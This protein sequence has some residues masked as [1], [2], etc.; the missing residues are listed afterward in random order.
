MPQP[1]PER[2]Q[3]D[4]AGAGSG[5]GEGVGLWSA[6]P[7]KAGELVQSGGD[8][9]D[10]RGVVAFARGDQGD[11]GL[12]RCGRLRHDGVDL[13]SG[14]VVLDL[15]IG[16]GG[17]HL[18][19]DGGHDDLPYKEDGLESAKPDLQSTFKKPGGDPAGP[20]LWETLHD[21]RAETGSS[22]WRGGRRRVVTDGQRIAEGSGL[23][24]GR[25]GEDRKRRENPISAQTAIG[26]RLGEGAREAGREVIHLDHRVS[27]CRKPP[28]PV[29]ARIPGSGADR[30]M[31]GSTRV[32]GAGGSLGGRED[33][34]RPVDAA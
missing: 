11:L 26:P 2:V 9:A 24:I 7:P 29:S 16:D 20:R 32:R 18:F 17:L 21:G 5:A 23:R 14:H 4:G 6:L 27:S 13:V 33:E 12:E 1:V 28:T 31:R 22:G 10:L 19:G 30:H 3:A 15:K 25:P 34:D 8:V